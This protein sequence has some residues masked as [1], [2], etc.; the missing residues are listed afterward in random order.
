MKFITQTH[1][2]FGYNYY[3]GVEL[4]WYENFT[5]TLLSII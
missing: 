2:F 4:M 5:D 3:Q 1:V